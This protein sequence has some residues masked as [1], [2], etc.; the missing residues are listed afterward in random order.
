MEASPRITFR[1][2]SEREMGVTICLVEVND[3]FT[4]L[5]EVAALSDWSVVKN[6]IAR[7]IAITKT[8]LVVCI[9][10]FS[11]AEV[12]KVF[13]FKICKNTTNS[14]H[15]NLNLFLCPCRQANYIENS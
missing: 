10:S 7:L 11:Q 15:C 13:S 4:S 2:L 14:T 5:A 12:L 6:S 3:R 1:D 8:N 9:I